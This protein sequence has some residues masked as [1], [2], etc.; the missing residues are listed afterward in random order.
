MSSEL[1]QLIIALQDSVMS[2][3]QQASKAQSIAKQNGEV[4]SGLNATNGSNCYRH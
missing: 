2:L 1:R 4:Q 3:E